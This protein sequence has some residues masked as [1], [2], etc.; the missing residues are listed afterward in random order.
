[1]DHMIEAVPVPYAMVPQM[2]PQCEPHLSAAI[3]RSKG[4]TMRNVVDEL[5]TKEALLWAVVDGT[6]VIG[7]AVTEIYGRTAYVAL[8]G[9][10]RWREWRYELNKVE[11]WA[12]AA[13]CT[14]LEFDGRKGWTRLLEKQGYRPSQRGRFKMVKDL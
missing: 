10:E 14:S 4:W 9:G 5:R 12:R 11:R 7:A 6:A 3:A 13:G 2:W 1:M 8:V